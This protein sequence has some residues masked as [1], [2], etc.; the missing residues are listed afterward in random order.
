MKNLLETLFRTCGDSLIKRTGVLTGKFD[1]QDSSEV[2][3]PVLGAWLKMSVRQ[4]ISIENYLN[5]LV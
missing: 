4:T 1:E 2:Q 5:S 3:D